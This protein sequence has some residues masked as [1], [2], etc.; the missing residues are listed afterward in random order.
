MKIAYFQ[1]V[2]VNFN[3][4]KSASDFKF[5]PRGIKDAV[6]SKYAIKK[7][8]EEHSLRGKYVRASKNTTPNLCINY[9]N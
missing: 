5:L 7:F 6:H 3:G 2:Y 8:A 1:D 9:A 4:T